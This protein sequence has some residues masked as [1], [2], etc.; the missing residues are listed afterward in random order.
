VALI[1]PPHVARQFATMPRL[2]AR[3]LRERLERIAADPNGPQPGAKA[4]V[5]MQ[6]TFRV[7]QGDWRAIYA[8]RD[9]NVIVGQVGNRKEVYR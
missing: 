1:I 8:I 4:M 2:D 3:R 7:R 6:G 5:G 9:G